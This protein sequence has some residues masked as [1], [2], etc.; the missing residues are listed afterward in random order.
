MQADLVCAGMDM[1]L[2]LAGIR[3]PVRAA[4]GLGRGHALRGAH[5]AP[6]LSLAQ[7]SKAALPAAIT[8][9]SASHPDLPPEG[10]GC[11]LQLASAAVCAAVAATHRVVDAR[12][13]LPARTLGLA[14]LHGAHC[15]RW[16]LH[17][18]ARGPGLVTR[19]LVL[20]RDGT[21]LLALSLLAPAV[22]VMRVPVVGAHGSVGPVAGD[23]VAG[24][25]GVAPA[26]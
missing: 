11:G 14:V 5:T 8:G 23:A 26:G 6:S 22:V 10:T 20:G 9:S 1:Q 13:R 4:H 18:K 19:A 16:A 7:G 21:L 25:A 17:P 2:T 24:A 15:P 3:V 12:T